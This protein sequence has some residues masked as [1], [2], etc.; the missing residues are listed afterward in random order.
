M[1]TTVTHGRRAH[2]SLSDDLDETWYSLTHIGVGFFNDLYGFLWTK[3]LRGRTDNDNVINRR[4][5][6]FETVR[7]NFIPRLKGGKGRSA[8]K[9]YEEWWRQRGV[10][11]K[12][13]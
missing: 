7:N 5:F 10:D 6:E 11:G 3:Q 13:R 8:D 9:G 4:R 2:S 12:T 1:R